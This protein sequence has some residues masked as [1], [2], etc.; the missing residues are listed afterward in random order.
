MLG[1]TE[2]AAEVLK[3]SREDALA[4]ARFKAN[5]TN[6]QRLNRSDLQALVEA[7]VTEPE[8]QNRT[9]SELGRLLGVAGTTVAA[10]RKRLGVCPTVR[11]SSDGRV[12]VRKEETGDG[13]TEVNYGNPPA[14]PECPENYGR[15]TLAARVLERLGEHL[16]DLAAS[17]EKLKEVLP[18][19]SDSEV[20]QAREVAC[21]MV[22]VAQA[23]CCPVAG[24][25]A[26]Q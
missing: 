5:R 21:Q 26:P 7:V 11:V 24:G 8:Y 18:Y 10:T 12:W 22:Q 25:G 20:Q 6:G 1:Q 15:E 23:L 14:G 3:G 13:E 2:I 19:A 9:D 16:A 17:T 4:H